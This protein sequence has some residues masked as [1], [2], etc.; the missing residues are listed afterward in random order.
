MKKAQTS[1]EKFLAL[2]DAEKDAEVAEF[3]K[4]IDP[5]QWRP[6]NAE[7]RKLWCKAKRRM[8]RPVV[9]QGSKVVAVTIERGLL[10]RADAFAKQHAM[11]RAQMI[12]KGLEIV[13]A[14]KVG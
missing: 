1:I 3:E 2:T 4:G 8:G 6:L 13:M 12:A 14:R 10:K 5:S 9:G 11:K 7:E